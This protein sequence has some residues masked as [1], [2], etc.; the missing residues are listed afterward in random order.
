MTNNNDEFRA[1]ATEC[2]RMADAT[3]NPGDRKRWLQMAQS[4]LRMIKPPR[5]SDG[6]RFDAAE[7]SE[8]THQRKSD[9]SH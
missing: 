5:Q 3:K 9:A 2:Q 6:E 4:W 8:G 7:R 1:N